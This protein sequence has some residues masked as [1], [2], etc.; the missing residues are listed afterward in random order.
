MVGFT[1][2]WIF[3]FLTNFKNFALM[4]MQAC[5]DNDSDLSKH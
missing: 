2:F 4:I 1:E 3:V 5:N